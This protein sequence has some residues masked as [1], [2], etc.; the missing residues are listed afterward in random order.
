MCPTSVRGT[1]ERLSLFLEQQTTLVIS[2]SM[3]V[4][5]EKLLLRHTWL[6]P[7][8]IALMFEWNGWKIG[9]VIMIKFMF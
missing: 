9:A 2:V 5:V 1:I 4:T 3:F 6:P 7:S 8:L